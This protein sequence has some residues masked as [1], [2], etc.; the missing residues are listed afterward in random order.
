MSTRK[1]FLIPAR[2]GSKGLPG[3]N[4]KVLGTKPLIQYSIEFAQTC[5]EE[6]DVLCVS[7]NDE[8]V[9]KVC[10]NLGVTP[11]FVRPEELATDTSSSMD[12][13]SHAINFYK[14]RDVHFSEIVL[15]QPTSPF[16]LESDFRT[17]VE[18]YKKSNCDMV[19]SVK[20]VKENPYFNLFKQDSEGYLKGFVDAENRV[21]RRQDAPSVYAY[22]GSIY[23]FNCNAFEAL[24]GL[25]FEKIVKYVM[26]DSRSVDIDTLIDWNIAEFYLK[27]SNENN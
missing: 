17:M 27:Q 25:G 19:V 12:V 9:L 24:N 4:T 26:P 13:I 6:G 20:E 16:R 18:L 10:E 22:N 23:L 15:L 7:S 14:E 2:A 1:L 11:P 3:K 21:T 8:E 5:S